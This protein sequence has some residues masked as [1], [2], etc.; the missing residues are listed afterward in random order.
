MRFDSKYGEVLEALWA[1]KVDLDRIGFAMG[2][3]PR[4]GDLESPPARGKMESVSVKQMFDNLCAGIHCLRETRVDPIARFL[5]EDAP[6]LPKAAKPAD[7]MSGPVEWAAKSVGVGYVPP[8][9]L[10]DQMLASHKHVECPPL[11]PSP[12]APPLTHT[13]QPTGPEKKS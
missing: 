8:P 11:P 4:A 3:P 13:P 2:V 10:A 7:Q 1:M 6:P 12:L 5:L 9:S